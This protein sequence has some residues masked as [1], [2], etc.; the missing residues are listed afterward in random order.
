MRRP[1]RFAVVAAVCIAVPSIIAAKY[2][3]PPLSG[4]M[5][6][7]APVASQ[8]SLT[9]VHTHAQQSLEALPVAIDGALTPERIPD[10]LA[11]V[12]F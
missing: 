12:T 1:V 5:P 7:S 6:S 11:F 3:G 2:V 4:K 8:P 10:D 9:A